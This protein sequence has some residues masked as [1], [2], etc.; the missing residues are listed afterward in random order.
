MTSL[1]LYQLV[2]DRLDLQNKLQELNFDEQTVLD[3]LEGEA[4]ELEAKI[5]DYGFVIRNMEAFVGAMKAEEVR[6]TERR[7][8]QE[9]K[10]EHIKE[11]LLTN[12]QACGI[13]KIDCPVFSLSIK[14][15]PPKVILDNEGL[16]PM[17]YFKE[18]IVE[19]IFSLQKKVVADA[20]KSGIEVPGAHLE[21][22]YR[23]EIK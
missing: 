8:R 15:N 3:T 12:M 16:I 11:W 9:K 2:G 1:S 4:T 7:M 6:M 18:V 13:T 23:I 20:I 5:E 21:T 10:V 17:E 14:Q 19:P 22:G